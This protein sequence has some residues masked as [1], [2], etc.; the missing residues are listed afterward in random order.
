M[1]LSKY[2]YLCLFIFVFALIL[3]LFD[4]WKIHTIPV[5]NFFLILSHR[6]PVLLETYIYEE[7]YIFQQLSRSDEDVS[8]W[9]LCASAWL[10]EEDVSR[11]DI[12]APAW[13][14]LPVW[15]LGSLNHV[16]MIISWQWFVEHL[17][18]FGINMILAIIEIARWCIRVRFLR[19]AMTCDIPI[20]RHYYSL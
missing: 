1:Y 10:L 12:C 17:H 11:W 19:A 18:M 2:V 6:F 5:V 16:N 14:F 20:I 9:D 7:S 3:G 13:T 8:Q 15:I 4:F